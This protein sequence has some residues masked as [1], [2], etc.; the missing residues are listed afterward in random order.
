MTA[1]A[2]RQ[3]AHF[4]SSGVSVASSGSSR[5]SSAAHDPIKTRVTWTGDIAR[6]V[7]ARCVSCHGPEARGTMSLASYEEARPWARAIKE[8]VLTRRMP[9][10]RAARGY[11]D[12][13]ND[14]S[15]S[16]FQIALVAAWADGGAPRGTDTDLERTRRLRPRSTRSMSLP[17]TRSQRAVRRTARPKGTLLAIRPELEPKGSIGIAVNLPDGRREIVGWIRDYDPRISDHVPP[18]RA[19]VSA[20]RA[21]PLTAEAAR[22][23]LAHAHGCGISMTNAA[24]EP[25]RRAETAPTPCSV[26]ARGKWGRR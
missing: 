6:I 18:A 26:P 19:A 15:L 3:R 22:R 24:V 25:G 7:E 14:P 21:A 16:P 20:R 2:G 12:F 11:G 4:L 8:E 10:W 13:S 23:V 1:P 5:R 9:T 17:A